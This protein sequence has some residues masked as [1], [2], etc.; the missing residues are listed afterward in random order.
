MD[1]LVRKQDVI[2]LIMG[3]PPE[4]HYPSWYAEQIRALQPVQSEYEE[5]T[6]EKAASEIACGSIESAWYWLGV[7]RQMEQMGYVICKKR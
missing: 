1:E 3:Q 2:D 7:I 6:P 5:L 4:P